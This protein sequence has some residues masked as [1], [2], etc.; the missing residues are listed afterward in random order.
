[1]TMAAPRILVFAGSARRESL[2]KKLARVAA[3]EA[4]ALA[5]ADEAF[6]ESGQLKDARAVRSV[7]NLVGELIE[8]TRRVHS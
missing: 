8:T 3:A 6:D 7:K 4:L 5:H 2:N 1:M